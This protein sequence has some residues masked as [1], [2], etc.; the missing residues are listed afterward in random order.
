[1]VLGSN[2]P[3]II[4]RDSFTNSFINAPHLTRLFGVISQ[5]PLSHAEYGVG[6][7]PVLS[8]FLDNPVSTLRQSRLAIMSLAM[9][10][11]LYSRG[12]Y[13]MIIILAYKRGD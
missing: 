8:F 5:F 2:K 13:L 1:M 6:V 11:K 10:M 4:R 7:S 3:V 9:N 12:L